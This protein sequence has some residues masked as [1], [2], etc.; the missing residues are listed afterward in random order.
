VSDFDELIRLITRW[1]L[2]R[3]HELDRPPQPT[4][5][6]FTAHRIPAKEPNMPAAFQVTANLPPVPTDATP[7]V[8][9]QSLDVTVGGTE[10]PGSPF[11]VPLTATTQVIGNFQVGD[12]VACSLTYLDA[13]G[14]PSVPR[15]ETTT[16]TAPVGPPEPGE[17][18]LSVVEVNV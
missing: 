4:P 11:T 8:A 9:S 5:F 6:T 18:G 3:L 14:N 17:F 16:I 1:V 10:A 2:R 15:A 12:V 13:F 7:A